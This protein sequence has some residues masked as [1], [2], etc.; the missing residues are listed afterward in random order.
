MIMRQP[1]RLSPNLQ[2]RYAGSLLGL[3]CGDA[4]G[5]A[6]EFKKRGSFAP[7]TGIVGGGPFRLAAGQWTDD[8]SMA[9]CL[10]E[11]L[12]EKRY[13]VGDQM[14]RFVRWWREG[15]WSST[16]RC[17]DIGEATRAALQRFERDGSPYAGSTDSDAAG[18]GSLM[19]LAPVVLYFHPS[20]DDVLRYAADHSSTTHAAPEA[21]ECC[22]LLGLALS[23]ALAGV[24][25]EALLEGALGWLHEDKVAAIAAGEFRAKPCA[26]IRGSGYA[27]ES[28]EAALWCIHDTANFRDAVLAAANLGEDADTTAAITGQLAGALYG[29]QE[30]PEE[31]S[32]LL[33]RREAILSLARRLLGASRTR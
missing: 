19:R 9:M 29:V 15:Y 24:G 3:A 25:K 12:V 8:T 17:F 26:Q 33:H 20:E 13:D 16:G 14:Q 28:L 2:D 31:W 7:L 4:L 6:V 18:N 30:V 32:R 22:Q 23:R 21:I 1:V 10:A 27:V 5:A 11:S